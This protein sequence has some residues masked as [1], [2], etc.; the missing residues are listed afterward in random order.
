MLELLVFASIKTERLVLPKESICQTW[1]V[2]FLYI[3]VLL[4]FEYEK[5]WW[6]TVG[7]VVPHLLV[8]EF[9]SLVRGEN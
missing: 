7:W 2:L 1:Q 3:D 8:S 5:I 6:R 9:S 4:F